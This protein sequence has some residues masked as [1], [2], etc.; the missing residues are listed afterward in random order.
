MYKVLPSAPYSHAPIDPAH[1]GD[2][3]IFDASALLYQPALRAAIIEE[4]V[5][6]LTTRL[7]LARWTSGNAVALPANSAATPPFR[8]A[9][10]AREQDNFFAW[11]ARGG[12]WEADAAP[13]PA[14]AES[15]SD[16]Q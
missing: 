12:V 11:I 5:A 2:C 6:L 14:D 4:Q 10:Y 13:A 8:A 1:V 16:L 7:A 3:A 9:F 15:S